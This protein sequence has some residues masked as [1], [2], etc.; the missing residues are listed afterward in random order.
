MRIVWRCACA[1][2]AGRRP[3]PPTASSVCGF[4]DIFL[5]LRASSAA[6][7]RG[8]RPDTG[9][10]QPRDCC[11]QAI[12]RG[13][14]GIHSCGAASRYVRS[15]FRPGSRSLCLRLRSPDLRRW[16]VG[17]AS[18]LWLFAHPGRTSAGRHLCHYS[19]VMPARRLRAAR[20]YSDD[21]IYHARPHRRQCMRG[22]IGMSPDLSG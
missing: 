1:R 12:A 22:S 7:S 17:V 18:P 21:L 8:R 6:Y 10:P 20:Q 4:P 16:G 11:G 15:G 9:A 13:S 3:V 14:W 5:A 19:G 2:S